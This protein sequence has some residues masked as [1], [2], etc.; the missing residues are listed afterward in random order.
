MVF[1]WEFQ[2]G[3][4]KPRHEDR[5]LRTRAT[6]AHFS[7][8]LAHVTLAHHTPTLH[9]C[10]KDELSIRVCVFSQSSCLHMFHRNLRSV[11]DA[12]LGCERN[13]TTLPWSMVR[14][15]V[16]PSGWTEPSHSYEPNSQIEISKTS[17]RR[18]TSPSR[19]N[20]ASSMTL[21]DVTI[22]FAASDITETTEAGQL[23]LLLLTQ[24]REVS[25]DAFGVS[26]FQQAA[27][28]SSPQQPASSK[29]GKSLEN[30]QFWKILETEARWWV[31]FKWWI[32]H[33]RDEKDI[34]CSEVCHHL[35]MNKN[36]FLF[37]R[38]N[39]L[40]ILRE[41]ARALQGEC[42]AQKRLSEAEVEM[43]RKVGIESHRRDHQGH[44][45]S[46]KIREKKCPSQEII[47]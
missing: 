24:E 40:H 36:D 45:V 21:D 31:T 9:R 18:S 12:R 41:A 4:S 35:N 37:E 25:A 14:F 20:T 8:V 6:D 34:V 11:S 29:C 43:D 30:V 23:I 33:C 17:T 10:L 47:Q 1:D 13:Q 42:T 15:M 46:R 7:C 22:T 44:D 39:L 16:W 32:N 3:L 27:A 5:A 19:L 38:K 28:R 2:G 26:V